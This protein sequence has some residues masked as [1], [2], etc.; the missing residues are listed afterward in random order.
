MGVLAPFV[1]LFGCLSTARAL[2]VTL[3]ISNV[4]RTNIN[5]S[6]NVDFKLTK[7]IFV[8][9]KGNYV[10]YIIDATSSIWSSSSG[11]VCSMALLATKDGYSPLMSVLVKSDSFKVKSYYYR[12]Y[13]DVWSSLNEASYQ[14]QLKNMSFAEVVLDVANLNRSFV[15]VRMNEGVLDTLD[16]NVMDGYKAT[17]IVEGGVAIW[18][19]S[20][21]TER[22]SS[23]FITKLGQK[24]VLVYLITVDSG[25]ITNLCFEKNGSEWSKTSIFNY[26]TRLDALKEKAKSLNTGTSKKVQAKKAIPLDISGQ[27]DR[28]EVDV[29]QVVEGGV[30][31]TIFTPQPHHVFNAIYDGTSILWVAK[32]G[33]DY[34]DNVWA[35]S[36][37]GSVLLLDVVVTVDG[38]PRFKYFEKKQ[39]TWYSVD[40]DDFE[41]A[42]SSYKETDFKLNIR[43]LDKSVVN[44]K[45]SQVQN[46]VKYL[47]TPKNNYNIMGVSDDKN[48]LWGTLNEDGLISAYL[49]TLDET[50]KFL[51]IFTRDGGFHHE[52]FINRNDTWSAVSETDFNA[53]LDSIIV[54]DVKVDI[55]EL[56]P[57][58]VDVMN[59][60]VQGVKGVQCTPKS[61][62]RLTEVWEGTLSPIWVAGEH[63]E[64]TGILFYYDNNGHVF[65]ADVTIANQYGHDFKFFQ[66]T[67]GLWEEVDKVYYK[68]KFDMFKLL[69]VSVDVGNFDLSIV[70][71]VEVTPQNDVE[72]RVT[73]PLRVFQYTPK[74]GYQ[75]TEVSEY[76][77]TVWSGNEDKVCKHITMHYKEEA[78]LMELLVSDS[79]G[80]HSK[81]FATKFGEWAPIDELE[82]NS[83]VEFLKVI[84]VT[85][86]IANFDHKVLDVYE[87]KDGNVSYLEIYPKPGYKV[88]SIASGINA[89]WNGVLDQECRY[90]TVYSGVGDGTVLVHAIV[91]DR[92]GENNLFFKERDGHWVGLTE[93]T[94]KTSLDVLKA[95]RTLLDIQSPDEDYVKVTKDSLFGH[96]VVEYRPKDG[97]GFGKVVDGADSV[98]SDEKDLC[99]GARLSYKGDEPNLVLRVQ[100]ADALS[101]LFFHKSGDKWVTTSDG[102]SL[103]IHSGFENDDEKEPVDEEIVVHF[104]RKPENVVNE[105]EDVLDITDDA[106]NA[107]FHGEVLN[108]R[109]YTP[110]PTLKRIVYG[111]QTIWESDE[112]VCQN[113]LLYCKKDGSHYLH[114]YTMQDRQLQ[115][116]EYFM[117]VSAEWMSVEREDFYRALEAKI[118]TY[119]SIDVCSSY[120]PEEIV[121][122]IDAHEF[123]YPNIIYNSQPNVRITSVFCGSKPIWSSFGNDYCV[124]ASVVDK[125]GESNL[126]EM[127]IKDRKNTVRRNYSLVD[128]EWV[129][130]SEDKFG[131]KVIV[132]TD[133]FYVPSALALA[134][135][136]LMV[137]F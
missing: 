76:K 55:A 92:Y 117:H 63:E 105:Q 77:E 106:D 137:A 136:I 121:E 127:F 37:N 83:T 4:D 15:D 71:K 17:K 95:T 84:S 70:D 16:V 62:Y 102:E 94:F 130:L 25:R 131:I 22:C 12:K 48:V 6:K 27:L 122:T 21:V 116:S 11:E 44:V 132:A 134:V 8:P 91:A 90:A 78:L 53:Y 1:L 64:C 66:N 38:R 128:G 43:D 123:G 81:Y 19:S 100:G 133:A 79:V 41:D 69:D 118:I 29:T 107:E 111:A 115:A 99:T 45:E 31:H 65:L 40:G 2:S 61:G 30:K 47:I 32:D 33:N 124:S 89:L 120:P 52:F 3:D 60:K 98:W 85:M 51:D 58:T 56:D 68:N 119:A 57:K 110:N 5:V 80:H 109:R 97:Y 108:V 23:V 88:T 34:C 24:S 103:D 10:D 112:H 104:T 113:I 13:G 28:E 87:D 125:D 50:P 54:H 36:K 135:A 14:E 101:F 72:D 7:E 73:P 114:L 26:H 42:L 35:Y 46:L 49:Y 18:T 39:G 129:Y 59:I 75:I 9:A 20:S 74:E 86:D 82:Y 93:E 67:N 126:V 96:L